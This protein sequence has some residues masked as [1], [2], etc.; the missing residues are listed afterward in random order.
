MRV[1]IVTLVHFIKPNVNK[2][3]TMIRDLIKPCKLSK[4]QDGADMQAIFFLFALFQ[5]VVTFSD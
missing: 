1:M 5:N 3:V 4:C 2:N